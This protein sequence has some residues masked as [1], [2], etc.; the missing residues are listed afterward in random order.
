MVIFEMYHLVIDNSCW[1][2][3]DFLMI[4][5]LN[6]QIAERQFVLNV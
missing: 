2:Y 5:G 6:V 1:M 3:G 4:R